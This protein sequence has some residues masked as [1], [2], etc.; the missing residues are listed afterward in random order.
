MRSRFMVSL[1][2]LA[3]VSRISVLAPKAWADRRPTTGLQT[4]AQHTHANVYPCCAPPVAFVL[5]D[6]PPTPS[7]MPCGGQHSCCVRPGPSHVPDMPT[8][9]GNQRPEAR[10]LAKMGDER[11]EMDSVC[12]H[13]DPAH[14]SRPYSALS[15]VLRI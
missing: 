6:A 15:T 14:E 4:S 2:V 13:C 8:T 5:T 1:L 11:D 12:S 7:G 3:F 9:R 10:L